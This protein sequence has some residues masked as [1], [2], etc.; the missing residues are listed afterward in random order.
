[1]VTV[2]SW[3]VGVVCSVKYVVCSGK[4]GRKGGG[5]SERREGSLQLE[6]HSRSSQQI[7]KRAAMPWI[8]TGLATFFRLPNATYERG[9]RRMDWA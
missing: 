9:V 3:S 5:G 7:S 4:F 6:H 2:M 8:V 1:M